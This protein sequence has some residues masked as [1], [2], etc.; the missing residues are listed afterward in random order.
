MDKGERECTAIYPAFLEN[1][2]KDDVVVQEQQDHRL[3]KRMT[4]Y[5]AIQE[6]IDKFHKKAENDEKVREKMEGVVKTVNIDLGEEKYSLKLDNA[7]VTNYKEGTIENPDII[8]TSTPEN[9]QALIDGTLRPMKA[10]F[11]KKFTVKGKF[12]D[13]MHLKSLF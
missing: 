2:Q 8:F 9:L 5:D 7:R 4:M 3:V 13:L 6:M 12:E 11:T 10:Y 1:G